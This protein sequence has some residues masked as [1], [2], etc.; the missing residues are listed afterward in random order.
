MTLEEFRATRVYLHDP[1][2]WDDDWSGEAM[3]WL[4]HPVWVYLGW[5]VIS[6]MDG[7]YHTCGEVFDSLEDAEA[8]MAQNQDATSKTT[9]DI[10]R[11]LAHA[12]E[13]DA[14]MEYPPH[15]DH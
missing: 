9:N 6:V 15:D 14:Q 12:A 4:R 7:K 10:L 8:K 3:E 13:L 5:W 11:V 1:R 2:A